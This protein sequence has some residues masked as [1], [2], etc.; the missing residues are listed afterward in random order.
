M[1]G[2]THRPGYGIRKQNLPNFLFF[3]KK[4]PVFAFLPAHRLFKAAVPPPL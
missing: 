1:A 2:I 4:S 3:T